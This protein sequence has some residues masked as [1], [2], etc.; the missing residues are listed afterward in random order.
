MVAKGGK[1]CSERNA[2]DSCPT[3]QLVS[4]EGAL[5]QVR[6]TARTEC[7]SVL[8]AARQHRSGHTGTLAA[9]QFL[10][11]SPPPKNGVTTPTFKKF[12]RN[13]VRLQ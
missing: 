12:H 7:S 8:K 5:F 2:T 1:H 9:Y 4:K 6:S 10:Y 11:L 13:V 3:E